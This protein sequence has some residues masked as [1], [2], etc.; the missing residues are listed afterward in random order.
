M[1]TTITVY[2]LEDP[3]TSQKY[4]SVTTA[5]F[6]RLVGIMTSRFNQYQITDDIEKKKLYHHAC[7]PLLEKYAK[8]VMLEEYECK[9]TDDIRNMKVQ[10]ME[11]Y[12][13]EVDPNNLIKLKRPLKP[14]FKRSLIDKR[15]R[16]KNKD[17]IN[18]KQ[19]DKRTCHI[20]LGRYTRA[21]KYNHQK[22]TKHTTAVL[23]QIDRDRNRRYII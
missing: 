13:K 16:A 23:A 17:N 2:K 15:Y 4:V 21:N 10:L 6:K 19:R 7:F 20:C 8:I 3:I 11:K 14:E 5:S 9:P 22:T 1:T 12:T 18:Q